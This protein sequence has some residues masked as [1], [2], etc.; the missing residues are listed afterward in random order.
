MTFTDLCP[1]NVVVMNCGTLRTIGAVPSA[2]SCRRLFKT[3]IMIG[4]RTT[5]A[6]DEIPSFEAVKAVVHVN[7]FVT[8]FIFSSLI[9]IDKKF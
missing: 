5:L 7:L 2:V 9:K 3:V 1:D 8:L 4:R 6:N